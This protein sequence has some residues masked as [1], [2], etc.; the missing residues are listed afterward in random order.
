M[1]K[2]S[3]AEGRRRCRR[4]AVGLP[5]V[6]SRGGGRKRKGKR[7]RKGGKGEKK[8]KRKTMLEE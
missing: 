5:E 1:W 4:V 6:G 7:V 3:E 8:M 2:I